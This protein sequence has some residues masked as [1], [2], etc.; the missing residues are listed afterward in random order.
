MVNG[1]WFRITESFPHKEYTMKYVGVDLHKHVITLCVVVLVS[2]NK[3]QV[4]SRQTLRCDDAGGIQ[5]FFTAL[6]AFQAVVEA[7]ASY[8]W[9]V[10]LIETL[11]DRVVLAHP[12]KLRVIAESTRKTDKIDAQVLAEFLALGMIPEAYRPTPRQ[13]EYRCLVRQRYYIRRRISSVKCKLRHKLA[14]YNADLPRL[15]GREGRRHLEELPVSCADRFVIDQLREELGHH[16]TRLEA[17]DRELRRFAAQAPAPEREARAVLATMPCVAE[18]TVD[19]VLSELAD[20]RRFRSQK[21]AASYSGLVPGYRSSAGHQKQLGI[22]HEGSRLLRWA[23]VQTA[24]R[25]VGKTR[26]WGLIY[27]KLRQR[28]GPKKAIV[29]VA[30]RVLCVMVAML[31]SGQSYRM[32]AE[33]G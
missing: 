2:G 16:E 10:R 33:A 3:R 17:I 5:R 32:A 20:V 9:F 7:T 29:A 31:Q 18:V 23:L 12:K 13:R 8:E 15:F 25:L 14:D 21:R 22:T 28:C 24:W 30:R 1:W 27:E 26:R 4:V 6:G 11:A 19:V